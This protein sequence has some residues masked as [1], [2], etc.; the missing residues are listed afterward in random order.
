[1]KIQICWLLDASDHES[2]TSGGSLRC[3]CITRG[4]L[5][6]KIRRLLTA[7]HWMRNEIVSCHFLITIKLNTAES[8]YFILASHWNLEDQAGWCFFQTCMTW[9]N[10]ACTAG[11]HRNNYI[12]FNT[13]SCQSISA[14]CSQLASA[15]FYWQAWPGKKVTGAVMAEMKVEQR[16]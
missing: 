7:C 8:L 3:C 1:M 13:S 10:I 9:C 5:V 11:V 16:W 4:S 15:V 12:V 2:Q 6:N 14:S